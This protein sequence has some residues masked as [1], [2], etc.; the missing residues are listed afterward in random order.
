MTSF[1]YVSQDACVRFRVHEERVRV[2]DR[3]QLSK[4]AFLLTC[5]RS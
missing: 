2:R 1:A 5:F 4:A 3:D